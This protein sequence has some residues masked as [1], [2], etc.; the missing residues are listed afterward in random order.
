MREG[1]IPDGVPIVVATTLELAWKIAALYNTS[2]TRRCILLGIACKGLKGN[3]V[4]KVQ[5]ILPIGTVLNGQYTLESL[6][7]KGGFGNVY[8]AR[9]L[10]DNRQ[11]FALV[12]LLNPKEQEGYRLTLDYV[13][14][15][16]VPHHALPHTQ[17]V[18]T[19]DKLGRTFLLVRYS[20]EPHLE[21]LR[22]QQPEQRFPLSVVR[23]LMAPIVRAVSHLHHQHPPIIH[24]NIKPAS[25][26]V[27]RAAGGPVLVMLLIV[28][29]QGFAA[30]P[31]PYFAPCYG[32]LEQYHGAFGPRTD[33]YSLGATCYLL[34]TGRV[35]PDALYR[36]THLES[37]GIDLLKP[38]NE[39]VYT[40]PR[41]TAQAIQQA[42]ALEE[43]QRFPSVEQFWEALWSP[44]S[45]FSMSGSPSGPTTSPPPPATS[46]QAMARPAAVSLPKRSL[47][48]RSLKLGSLW[49]LARKQAADKLA[50]VP[51]SL[52]CALCRPGRWSTPLVPCLCRRSR[53]FGHRHTSTYRSCCGDSSFS[54][55]RNPPHL[56]YDP[57]ISA[58]KGGWILSG[59]HS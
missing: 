53:S 18:F 36:A 10:S 58:S 26:I 3:N 33:L 55:S 13:S 7:G 37:S 19:D 56:A 44:R 29:D 28:K 49:P 50:P 59:H 22:V 32:A 1:I 25:I 46:E 20:E 42:M 43:E 11:L 17:S 45:Q 35:P 38:A 4:Q 57:C 5:P 48:S 30:R 15:P 40:I 51:Q 47:V 2:S 27:P 21:L 54:A 14:P 34:L 24:Q 31:G 52:H 6:L 8:L 39:V 41:F 16:P 23:T 9:D 12:E